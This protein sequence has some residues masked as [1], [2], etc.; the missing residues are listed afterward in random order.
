M[1]KVSFTFFFAVTLL[2]GVGRVKVAFENFILSF[3]FET[4]CSYNGTHK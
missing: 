3:I 4:N 1:K 2:D